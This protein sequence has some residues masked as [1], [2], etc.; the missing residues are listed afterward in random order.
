[1]E[2]LPVIISAMLSFVLGFIGWSIQS[3]NNRRYDE[4]KK[5]E[6]TVFSHNTQ[7]AVNSK[8][9]EKEA[10]R[11]ED[12]QKSMDNKFEELNKILA[13][14]TTKV[15]SEIKEIKDTVHKLGI[16]IAKITK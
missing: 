5:L 2:Y 7:I 9:D 14:F 12:H 8:S 13:G 4:F 15:E 11:F 6:A 3:T 10:K 1:M 16:D